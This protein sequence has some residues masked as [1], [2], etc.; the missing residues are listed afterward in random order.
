MPTVEELKAEKERLEL[1]AQVE[2]LRAQ[3]DRREA[4]GELKKENW[5][6]VALGGLLAGGVGFLVALAASTFFGG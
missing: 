6:A 5:G 1:E 2:K 3:K 4:V